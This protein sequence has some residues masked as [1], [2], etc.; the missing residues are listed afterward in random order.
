MDF[1]D[2]D[3]KLIAIL[4]NPVQHSLSPMIHNTAFQN[5]GLNFIYIAIDLPSENLS[6]AM[7]GLSSLGFSGVNVT[8]P[9][10][11]SVLPF[12]NHLS[13]A[14]QAIGAVN[15]IVCNH[16]QLY[17]DNTDIIGFL[18]PI[19]DL[20]LHGTSMTILGAGGA[21]RAAAYGL[22]REFNP[23]P[24]TLVARRVNQAQKIADDFAGLSN[25][26][27]V[28]DFESASPAIQKSRLIV[29]STSVGMYPQVHE[30]PW[31]K[32]TDFSSD[33][34]VYDLVYRP[35]QTQLLRQAERQGATIITGLEMLIQQAAAAYR[36]WTHQEMPVEVIRNTL[37][38]YLDCNEELY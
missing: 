13:E 8:I 22:L 3:T 30:T 11:E 33:Q 36:Q 28:S 12:M 19:R 14:A 7:Q 1:P 35:N 10:K 38:K 32:S 2:V 16:G 5:Q 34:V 6:I 23:Q 29:N 27:E 25:Q 4:G 24:L 26:V 37:I 20:T 31:Q 9:H 18:S 21:A 17:G 15:T